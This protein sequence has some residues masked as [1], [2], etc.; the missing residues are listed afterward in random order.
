MK[1]GQNKVR[2]QL[3]NGGGKCEWDGGGLSRNKS[4]D[5]I[6]YQMVVGSVSQAKHLGF[7]GTKW[8]D[9]M[10]TEWE[11]AHWEQGDQSGDKSSGP[12]QTW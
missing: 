9:R 3:R 2:N 4:R 6:K 8:G 10:R 12:G 1:E 5:A 11:D 7:F